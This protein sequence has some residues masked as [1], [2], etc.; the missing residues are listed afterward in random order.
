MS[1]AKEQNVQVVEALLRKNGFT[2]I[3]TS[4]CSPGLLRW[5][6][7]NGAIKSI[8]IDGNNFVKEQEYTHDVKIEIVYYA[9]RGVFGA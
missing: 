2:A 9:K 1:E 6:V 8:T 3:T 5:R 4:P 7:A